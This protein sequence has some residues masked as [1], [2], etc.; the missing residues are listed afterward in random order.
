MRHASALLAHEGGHDVVGVGHGRAVLLQHG[1]DVHRCLEVVRVHSPVG[2]VASHGDAQRERCLDAVVTSHI[3]R[4]LVLADGRCLA[5]GE[6]D[7]LLAEGLQ[8]AIGH[9]SF[10]PRGQVAHRPHLLL[11]A[12]VHKG[13]GEGGTVGY[14]A[15]AAYS[16]LLPRQR[17]ETDEGTPSDRL[18][19]VTVLI[20]HVAN[21]EVQRCAFDA[22][23]SLVDVNHNL[24]V[25]SGEGE[26]DILLLGL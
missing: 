1:D 21:G 6:G 25:R 11:A 19:E 24:V 4:L 23:G 18:G 15:G 13:G 16:V 3:D 9:V 26:A 7:G 12:L 5:H 10:Q 22:G 14:L 8:V 2:H 17:V 20:V